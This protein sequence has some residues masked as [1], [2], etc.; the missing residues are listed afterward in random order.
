MAI[1]AYISISHI[2][3]FKNL[4][5]NKKYDFTNLKQNLR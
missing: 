3:Q 1:P 4:Y 5:A 2:P